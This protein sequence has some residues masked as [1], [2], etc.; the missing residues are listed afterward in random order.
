MIWNLVIMNGMFFYMDFGLLLSMIVGYYFIVSQRY[1]WLLLAFFLGLLNHGGVIYL[2]V[3]FAFFNYN[4]IFRLKTIFYAGAMT[5]I[6]AGTLAL[7]DIMLPSSVRGTSLIYNLPRNLELLLEH[8]KHLILRDFLFNFGGL[9]FFVLLFLINGTWR[10]FKGPYLYIHLMIIIF[11]ITLMLTFS[12]EEMRN[13]S[14]II[15]NILILSLMFL[16]TFENSFLKPWDHLYA[17][18]KETSKIAAV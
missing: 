5:I 17:K 3:S 11:F 8:P 16:S 4:K 9:H 13:Y 14:A 1:N 10:K 12:V 15:P 6:F 2:I 18:E 7:I